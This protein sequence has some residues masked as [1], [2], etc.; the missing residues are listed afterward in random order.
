MQARKPASYP[1][2]SQ[3]AT[4]AIRHFRRHKFIENKNQKP[5][6]QTKKPTHKQTTKHNKAAE[7]RNRKEGA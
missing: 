6:K 5:N 3:D 7:Q 1:A 2:S 4:K